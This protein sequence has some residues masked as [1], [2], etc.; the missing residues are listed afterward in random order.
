MAFEKTRLTSFDIAWMICH[1]CRKI[2]AV[3][4][5]LGWIRFLG[6]DLIEGLDKIP[7]KVFKE[8]ANVEAPCLAH[9]GDAVA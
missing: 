1:A 6:S 3:L 2:L 7:G 9:R 5:V 8:S 4:L